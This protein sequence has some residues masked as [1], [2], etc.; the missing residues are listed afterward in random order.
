MH[1]TA[2]KNIF[3]LPLREKDI[4]TEKNTLFT[5]K[6][7]HH[8]LIHNIFANYIYFVNYYVYI[9]I[10]F[11]EAMGKMISVQ[12]RM[13]KKLVEAIDHWID[14]GWFN[15]RSDAI[16]TIVAMYE[17]KKREQQYIDMLDQRFHEMEKHPEQFI[18][19]DDIQ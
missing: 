6:V 1:E 12:V 5:M 10:T 9:I 11:L 8:K 14:E 16:K 15:S 4:F 19:L 18:R 7:K 2:F 17:A 3:P 13:P